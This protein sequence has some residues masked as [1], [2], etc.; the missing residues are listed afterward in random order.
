MA[1]CTASDVQSVARALVLGQGNN[2]TASDVTGYCNMVAGEIDAIL[3]TRGI[4]VPVAVASFPEAAAFLLSVN[5]KG[6]AWMAWDAIGTN[7]AQTDKAKAAYDAAIKLLSDAKFTLNVPSDQARA[8]VRAPFQTFFPTGQTYDP[9]QAAIS[10]T[11]GDGISSG[12]SC[13]NPANPYF[14]R[15]QRY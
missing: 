12:N 15:Q 10:G 13:L 11:P 9:A 5:A 1:Y 14:S 6:G 3:T 2:P 4:E 7:P 8:Q